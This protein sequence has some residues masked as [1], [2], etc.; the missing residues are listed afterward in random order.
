M[1]KGFLTPI[2]LNGLE[3]L[4]ARLQNL[5]TAPSSPGLGQAY[6]DTTLGNA[7]I[8]GSSGWVNVVAGAVYTDQNAQDA[9][10]AL[11]ANGTQTGVTVTYSSTNHTLSFSVAADGAAGTATLRSLGTAGTQAAAGNDSRLSDTR[12]PT[13]GSVTNAK[14]ATG[15]AISADKLADGT[16][17]VVMT[18]GERTKLQGVATGATA[19]S[20]DA[21]L[22]SRANHTGTQ[23]ADTIIAGSTNGVYTLT[24][25]SKLAGIASGATNYTDS[26]ARANRL[27][28]FATPAT[29]VSFGGYTQTNVGTPVNGTDGANKNYVDASRQGIDFK[30]SVQVATTASITLSGLQAIDGYTTLAGDR[31]LV[32]NQST[33]SANGIYVAA[34]GTWVRSADAAS[35]GQ[36]S[37]GMI[38]YVENGTTNAGTQWVLQTTGS[39]TVGTTALSFVQFSGASSTTAGN[40]LTASGNAFNVGQGT[41]IVVAAD[42]ISIDTSVVSRVATFTIG[43]GSATSYTLTHNFNKRIVHVEIM[44]N[45]GNYDTVEADITRPSVNTVVVTFAT[46]PAANALAAVVTG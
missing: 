11:I 31:V 9:I 26:N 17:N 23:S 7:R 35:T 36:V 41:G 33:A 3:I 29:S 10:G 34:S 37:S 42:A 45:S 24:E 19:N 21:Y 1:S 6:F 38:T 30:E 28:Q 18:S 4:N 8:Y 5:A 25:K 22:L 16:S 39:I 20:T 27:D 44:L 46:A 13:D 32:K 12:V 15:A 2:N 43:D 14:V 40:G